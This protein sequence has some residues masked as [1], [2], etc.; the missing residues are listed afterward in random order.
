MAWQPF[1]D[2]IAGVSEKSVDKATLK[3]N[4]GYFMKVEVKYL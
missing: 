1:E 3:A 2:K 4:K